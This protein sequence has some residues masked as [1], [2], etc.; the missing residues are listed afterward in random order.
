MPPICNGPPVAEGLG[1]AE[2]D[3]DGLGTVATAA[4]GLAEVTAAAVDA[5]GFGTLVLAGGAAG[6][7]A[8]AMARAPLTTA[9]ER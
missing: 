7:C 4:D 9:I 5:A 3:V 8:Q 6:V 2:A 1:D